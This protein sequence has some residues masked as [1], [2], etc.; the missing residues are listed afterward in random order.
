VTLPSADDLIAGSRLLAALPPFL[1]RPVSLEQARQTLTAR[2][3]RRTSDFL[4][5]AEHG[6]FRNPTSPYRTLL[7]M[8]GC[9]RADLERMVRQ[10]GLEGAL[11]RLYRAG[12]YLTVAELKGREPVRRGRSQFTF[13]GAHLRNPLA[14]FHLVGQSG[15][16]RGQRVDVSIDLGFVRDHAVNWRLALDALGCAGRPSAQW[17][18][19]GGQSLFNLLE[20][21]AYGSP[22]IRWFSQVDPASPGLHP[23]YRWSA[24]AVRWAGRAV[25]VPIP[26][27]EYVP[28]ESP[29]PAT[30]W[31]SSVLAAGGRPYM[32]TTASG[33][34][35]LGQAALELGIDLRGAHFSVGGEP[36]TPARLAVIHQAGAEALTSYGS[37][38]AG[39]IG[40]GCA[41][42]DASDDQHHYHDMVA[43]IQPGS[44][45]ERA[46]LP[47]RALLTTSLRTTAPLVLLNVS[48][49]DEAELVSR[50]CG[51]PLEKVGWS[52]HIRHVRSFEKLSA[53]GMT[54]LDHDVVR[55]LETILPDRFG[56]GP[57]DYQLIEEETADGRPRLRLLVHPRVGRLDEPAVADA[58]LA[59]I[60][61][62]SGAERVMELQW[63][64]GGVVQVERRA[65]LVSAAGKV[66]H[67]SRVAS[68]GG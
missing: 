21:V 47:A 11:S 54:F 45:G 63:R 7:R 25:G 19:P 26:R 32:G 68:T 59:A 41:A 29:E 51:C 23:R 55:V 62:G 52:T 38:E 2:F 14:S 57:L 64:Q 48:L 58:F 1:R 66:L 24:R 31:L 15:G 9:E 44:G 20:S 42:R 53:G 30:R 8:A 13:Q 3:E 4:R 18:V 61:G 49:G 36:L 12:V 50:S 60:G 35:R 28:I 6:I 17:T 56:G 16:S 43:L 39:R 33:A 40:Y 5:L 65:P 34:V 27:P 37:S 10:N 22:L 46:P 67:V